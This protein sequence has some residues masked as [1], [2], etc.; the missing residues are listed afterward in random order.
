[1]SL[2]Y[3]LCWMIGVSCALQL[4]SLLRSGPVKQ[5]QGWVF[6]YALVLVTIAAGLEWFPAWNGIAAASLWLVFILIPS[7]ASRRATR[8][9]QIRD[10]DSAVRWAWVVRIFHPADGWRAVPYLYQALRLAS[11]GEAQAASAILSQFSNTQ[12]PISRYAILELYRFDQRWADMLSYIQSLPERQVLN[13]PTTLVFYIQALGETGRLNDMLRLASVTAGLL[14]KNHQIDKVLLLVYAFAGLKESLEDLLK[15]SLAHLPEQVKRVWLLTCDFAAGRS[16]PVSK[17]TWQQ[18]TD[19]G[20]YS[21]DVARM[22]EHRLAF[23]PALAETTISAEGVAHLKKLLAQSDEDTRY[24]LHHHARSIRPIATVSIIALSLLGFLAEIVLGKQLAFGLGALIPELVATGDWWR[25]LSSQFL[26]VDAL[27]L[28]VNMLCLYG[29]GRLVEGV[30]V[31]PLYLLS[32]LL[33][34]TGSMVVVYYMALHYQGQPYTLFVGAS[35]GIMG[36]LGM[37]AAVMLRGWQ[38]DRSQAAFARLKQIGMFVA[39]QTAFDLSTRH[40][41]FTGHFAGLLL[42]LALGMIIPFNNLRRDRAN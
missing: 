21:P 7:L 8:A 42:G 12:S 4:S 40:V 6:V 29:L 9:A 38:Q 25:V 22:L 23:P 3:F 16:D 37:N 24:D 30:L 33:I 35:G 1:M 10:Y 28:T 11:Q 41:S 18:I 31:R 27:H 36:L 26:H 32:Y 20:Q 5:V 17:E 34:G 19:P 39:I 15:T 13:D 2:N 14:R